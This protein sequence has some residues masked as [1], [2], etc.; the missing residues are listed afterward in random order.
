MYNTEAQWT[1]LIHDHFFAYAKL[2][3]EDALAA[4]LLNLTL[5]QNVVILLF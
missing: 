1:I 3:R 5:Y 2:R 4:P